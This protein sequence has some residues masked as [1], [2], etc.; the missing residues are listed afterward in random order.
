MIQQI[1][2]YVETKINGLIVKVPTTKR[3]IQKKIKHLHFTH[4]KNIGNNDMKD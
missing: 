2:K 3:K 1:V 4:Q